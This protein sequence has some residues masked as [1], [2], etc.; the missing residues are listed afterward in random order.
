M[1]CLYP[2][3]CLTETWWHSKTDA[4][5]A[6]GTGY[7]VYRTDRNVRNSPKKRGGGTMRRGG[8][9]A[10]AVAKSLKSK[11]LKVRGSAGLEQVWVSIVNQRRRF[12]VGLLYLPPQWAKRQTF[13]WAHLKTVAN[14]QR[15]H[16]NYKII[17]VG[18]Y[19]QSLEWEKSPKVGAQLI[20]GQRLKPPSKVMLEGFKGWTQRNCVQNHQGK[21]LDLVWSNK[22][23][24]ALVSKAKALSKVDNFHPPLEFFA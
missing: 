13:M 20:G 3:V 12:L 1:Q 4:A 18:D 11:I 5:E 21:S 22:S 7:D 23:T 2:V 6:F 14:I 10:I 19:N 8:G 24:Q 15:S 16:P 9:V 17:V